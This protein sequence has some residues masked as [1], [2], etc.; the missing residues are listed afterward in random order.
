MAE[1]VLPRNIENF[2]GVVRHLMTGCIHRCF[3]H[4]WTHTSNMYEPVSEDVIEAGCRF[5]GNVLIR[6]IAS[7]IEQFIQQVYDG[8]KQ[9]IQRSHIDESDLYEFMRDVI[10]TR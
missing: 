4:Y 5:V 9:D 6:D 7:I 3:T 10:I 2:L 8:L 1:R